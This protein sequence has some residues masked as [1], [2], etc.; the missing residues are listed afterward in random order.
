MLSEENPHATL[1]NNFQFRCSVNVCFGVLD[2]QLFGPF[3]FERRLTGEGY[4]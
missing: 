2:D 1:T 4:L 3:I